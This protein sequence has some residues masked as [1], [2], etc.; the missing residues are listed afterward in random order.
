MWQQELA[1]LTSLSG[2]LQEVQQ[3]GGCLL[4]TQLLR[5]LTPGLWRGKISGEFS[6]DSAQLPQL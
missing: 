4:H 2:L 3:D 5:V 1:A 6:S